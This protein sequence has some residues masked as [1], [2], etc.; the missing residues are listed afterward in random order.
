MAAAHIELGQNSMFY[1]WANNKPAAL[2]KV[3]HHIN[4]MYRIVKD[5]FW[6][7]MQAISAYLCICIHIYDI[8]G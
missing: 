6:V 1:L 4:Y 3:S 2:N 5:M 7:A 8:Y